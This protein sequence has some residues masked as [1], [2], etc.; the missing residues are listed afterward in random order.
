M[1]DE[2]F[3]PSA[4]RNSSHRN[5]S[6]FSRVQLTNTPFSARLADSG[7]ACGLVTVLG[8]STKP[9]ESPILLPSAYSNLGSAF[10]LFEEL[11]RSANAPLIQTSPVESLYT[12]QAF[13]FD[14]VGKA[15][16]INAPPSA[17]PAQMADSGTPL[18]LWG[19][20]LCLQA[21]Q[22]R[23]AITSI[24]TKAKEDILIDNFTR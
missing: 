24:R 7:T 5:R 12:V 1:P 4:A 15:H 14:D 3:L 8:S 22:A 2:S 10:R 6:V 13:V 9:S 17:P 18:G 21:M 23:D 16:S 19:T 20:V 11:P